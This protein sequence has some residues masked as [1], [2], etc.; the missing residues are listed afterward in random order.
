M[1]AADVVN[2]EIALIDAHA[3]VTGSPIFGY[4][5]D[6]SQYVPRGHYT[7][8]EAFQRYF[9]AMMWYGR[10][11]FRLDRNLDPETR[12]RETRDALLIVHALHTA[13]V[14]R[15]T[16]L[17]V[18]DRI[19]DVTAFFVGTADDLTV[20]DY[21]GLAVEIYGHLPEP[22]DLA[23]DATLDAFIEQARALRPPA[24]LNT[25]I[26]PG[27]DKAEATMGFRF[28]GQRYIPDSAIFQQLI[29]DEVEGGYRGE[30]AVF[31]AFAGVRSF[32]RGLDVPAALGS[33]RALDIL[34]AAGDTDYDG[35]DAQLAAVRDEFASLE[36]GRWTSNLYWSWLNSLTPLLDV[37]GDGF[38]FFMRTQAWVDKSLNAWLGSWSQLRH[39][40][41]LYAKPT[42][43]GPTGMPRKPDGYV[44]PN[45]WLYARLAAL[46][47]QMRTGLSER[48]LLAGAMEL[49]L[50][51]MEALLLELK[52]IAELELV[53]ETPS[54]EQFDLIRG[55][56]RSLEALAQI[57]PNAP[58]T[59]RQIAVVAD[60]HTVP[61]AGLVLEEGVGDAFAIYVVLPDPRGQTDA[62]VVLR[63]GVFSYYEF[64]WAMSDRLTDEKWQA[65]DPRP[66]VPDWTSSYLVDR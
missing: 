1:A 64:K 2:A 34:T 3:G 31:T 23:D 43:P 60:V 14:G 58:D 54:E 62:Q 66:P 6:Y 46:T 32:P 19:Y 45:P 7:R 21:A 38:P 57:E 10:I 16:A 18:W 56:G 39:D 36:A 27:E 28:M 52:T 4:D 9:R 50:D 30:G 5:E 37:P 22:G 26:H 47:A 33:A 40:T 51:R 48:G 49:R 17:D 13:P 29:F 41:I 20:H 55:I 65:M 44:E 24:I 63:G 25:P 42:M 35:Y 61:D 53:G 8:D 59:D 12:R 15:Q 11:G